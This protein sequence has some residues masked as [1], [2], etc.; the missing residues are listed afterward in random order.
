[1][2]ITFHHPPTGTVNP[3]IDFEPWNTKHYPNN[4]EVGVYIC[5]LRA[6]VAGELKFIPIVVGEGN[7]YDALCKRHY[8]GKYVKA[9]N[10]L[11]NTPKNIS[12]KK[13]IWDFSKWRYE[14][15]DL[16][17]I[18][19]DMDFYDG[20][21]RNNR[22]NLTF[23]TQIASLKS[24]L[25]FQNNQFYNFRF[26]F[27]ETQADIRADEAVFLLG[28][29]CENQAYANCKYLIRANTTNLILTLKNFT[30]NF[31]FVYAVEPTLNLPNQKDARANRLAAE[32]ATKSALKRIGIKTTAD[33]NR[34]GN[35]DVNLEIDLSLVQNELVNI[36]NHPFNDTNG[37]YIKSLII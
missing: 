29:K 24:L 37:N 7:L 11:T 36:S 3:L 22:N 8:D 21:P 13:E 32:I 30:E 27:T 31:Y 20:L 12:E 10:N 14:L 1:M 28:E 2:T 9:F 17:D 18:Y 23:L 34:K 35:I 4:D 16:L 15:V 26:G 6:K 19:T 25:Y 33:S 5:G